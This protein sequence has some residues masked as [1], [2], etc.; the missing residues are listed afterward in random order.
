MG[1]RRRPRV[2]VTRTRQQSSALARQ[3]ELLG[4]EPVI[5]PLLEVAP[6]DSF[7]SLDA[8]LHTLGSFQ[9]LIVTS[10]NTVEA[11]ARRATELAL[12][13]SLSMPRIAAIGSATAA[14]L[15]AHGLA[16]YLVAAHPVAESLAS[17]LLAHALRPDGT[18]ARFLL[19]RAEQARDVLPEV[20]TAAGAEVVVV[21]A[22]RTVVP[23]GTAEQIRQIFAPTAVPLDAITFASSSSAQN[24][25]ALV[26]EAG[27]H[28]PERAH[29]VS[30][31]P[32]TSH[33]LRR[34]GY[35]PHIEA[36]HADVAALAA[37]VAKALHD[38][39]LYR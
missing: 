32:I 29:R 36:A 11:V 9:W 10:A 19:A 22:Y 12:S 16:P 30:I 13:G 15:E 1:Q 2:L 24:L 7:A 27:L 4:L 34:L 18:P 17:A 6:P 37:A 31:G 5:L 38:S 25:L 35:P 14:A 8:A 28:L 33:T 3:L 26:N 20:L 21:T 39:A 23:P